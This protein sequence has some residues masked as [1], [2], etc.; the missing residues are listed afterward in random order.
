MATPLRISNCLKEE[1]KD[2]EIK[3]LGI[4]K[5]FFMQSDCKNREKLEQSLRDLGLLRKFHEI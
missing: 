1:V 4:I 5:N 2:I 3:K